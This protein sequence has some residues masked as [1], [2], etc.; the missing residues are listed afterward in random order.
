MQEVSRGGCG[1]VF[2]IG[3]A[4]TGQEGAEKDHISIQ[5][6]YLYLFLEREKE[7]NNFPWKLPIACL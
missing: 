4:G 6:I 2:G 5:L 3:K 1:D 7:K